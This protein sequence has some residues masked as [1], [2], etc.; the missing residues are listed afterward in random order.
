MVDD[1]KFP[2]G[3]RERLNKFIRIENL[4]SGGPI[5]RVVVGTQAF[6]FNRHDAH[7]MA[8][9]FRI[10]L[11]KFCLKEQNIV[12][13][14]GL[15]DLLN[16]KVS[17]KHHQRVEKLVEDRANQKINVKARERLGHTPHKTTE[18]RKGR[19]SRAR[20]PLGFHNVSLPCGLEITDQLLKKRFT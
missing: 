3:L 2:E 15:R 20:A 17:D 1:R 5:V 19:I 11:Y 18:I 4:K 7:I 10:S 16:E 8:H 13:A 9:Q 6:M 14:A 12:R